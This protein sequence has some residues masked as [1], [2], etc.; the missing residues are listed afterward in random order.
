MGKDRKISDSGVTFPSN[1]KH[2]W[3]LFRCFVQYFKSIMFRQT[4]MMRV[5]VL[6]LAMSFYLENKDTMLIYV[7]YLT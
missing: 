5:S 6:P 4:Q 1:F 7:R 3:A 2:Y